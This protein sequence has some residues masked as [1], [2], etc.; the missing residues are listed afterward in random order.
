LREQYGVDPADPSSLVPPE[1]QPLTNAD[2][3][4]NQYLDLL[5][6]CL[7]RLAAATAECAPASDPAPVSL[8]DGSAHSSPARHEKVKPDEAEDDFSQ[9]PQGSGDSGLLVAAPV[10]MELEVPEA[11]DVRPLDAAVDEEQKELH[12]VDLYRHWYDPR[13]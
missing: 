9:E 8:S 2:G 3:N 11:V 12:M 10:P 4:S 6:K 7:E 5:A 1:P 13:L